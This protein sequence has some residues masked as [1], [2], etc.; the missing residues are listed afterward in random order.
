MDTLV[1]AESWFY[2]IEK[3][4]GELLIYL[5]SVAPGDSLTISVMPALL[6]GAGP[7]IIDTLSVVMNFGT[8]DVVIVV[9][10]DLVDA[11]SESGHQTAVPTVLLRQNYPNPFNPT[12]TIRFDLQAPGWVLLMIYN[13]HG[14]KVRTLVSLCRAA[15]TSTNSAPAALRKC[16]VPLSLGNA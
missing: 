7:I 10:Q 2:Q 5:E 6:T 11:V 1:V 12:T 13:I 16:G 3:A 9:D 4:T 15:S 14:Q 8:R